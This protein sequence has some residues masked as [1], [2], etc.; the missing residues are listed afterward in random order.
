M[1]FQTCKITQNLPVPSSL[2]S[3]CL[4]LLVFVDLCF[5]LVILCLFKQSTVIIIANDEWLS[6]F[7]IF[8]LRS[9]AV[10]LAW[11]YFLMAIHIISV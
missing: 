6:I 5:Y 10:R 8:I 4:C 11:V 1:N 3:F 9:F 2:S 7:G